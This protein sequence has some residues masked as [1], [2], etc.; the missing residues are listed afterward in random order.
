MKARLSTL[1]VNVVLDGF[2]LLIGPDESPGIAVST[3][4]ELAA[5]IMQED[6]A[7]TYRLTADCAECFFLRRHLDT[8][9]VCHAEQGRL[10]AARE[11]DVEA[12]RRRVPYYAAT[13]A[14]QRDRW[15]CPVWLSTKY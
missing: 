13:R 12:S 11:A 14:C 3:I 7:V 6:V 2:A 4:P 9:S 1:L 10:S 8:L 15:R 5:V